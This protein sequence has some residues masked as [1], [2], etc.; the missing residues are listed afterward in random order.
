MELRPY[1]MESVN[2]LSKGFKNNLRQILCL[3][4]GA[5]KT[6]T[7]SDIVRRAVSKKTQ[8]LILTDRVELFEQ[9]FKALDNHLTQEIQVLQAKSKIE[10]FNCHSLVT[11]AMVETMKR[12]F[13]FGYDPTLIIIDEAHKGN[14]T[15]IIEKFQYA[16]VIGATATPVGKHIFKLYSNIVQNIDIPE[17]IEQSYLSPV[18][19]FQMQDD[20]SDVKMKGHDY[21]EKSL[22]EH[23]NKSKLYAGVVKEWK[24]KTL[25]KKTIVFNVNIEHAEK[26]TDEF[27]SNGI[28]SE[29]VT[30]DT[31][32]HERERILEAFKNNEFLVL[33]NCGILTTGYDEPS[34]EVVIM[35]RATKS[36]ALWLQCCGRGSRIFL[37]K[38][39][40][41]VLDF[42]MNHTEHGRWDEPRKWKLKE[43]KKSKEK[44][45]PLKTCPGC[46]A[47]LFV[48]ASTCVHCGFVYPVIEGSDELNQG[49]MV[50]VK[51]SVPLELRGKKIGDCNVEELAK[52][53]TSKRY[54]PV[55]IWRVVRSKGEGSIKDYAKIFGYKHGWIKRQIED[56]TKKEFTEFSNFTLK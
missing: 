51:S 55:F 18:K 54:K 22:Y 16:K 38:Q 9:T 27:I 6:V 3:P 40:F 52:L 12:R 11:V 31:P 36:L 45:A 15:A 21:E 13:I 34:I 42:G 35:N 14:F 5:G 53:Q 26:Q 50:E 25:N 8:C 41:T 2:E 23:F 30:S 47:M 48:S 39:F 46:D 24:E 32:K 4:T 7:F 10:N 20:F 44:A 19:A 49:V 29:C 17:L 43:K 33:N 28:S 1:Q 37:N 56:S